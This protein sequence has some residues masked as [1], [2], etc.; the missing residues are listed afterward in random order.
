MGEF[1]RCSIVLWMR[2]EDYRF[3]KYMK[4]GNEGGGGTSL[5]AFI[6]GHY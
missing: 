1:T 3:E 6:I 5:W 2:R 4:Q